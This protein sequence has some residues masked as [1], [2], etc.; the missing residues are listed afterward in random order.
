MIQILTNQH[1]IKTAERAANASFELDAEGK[2]SLSNPANWAIASSITKLDLSYCDDPA[3]C[4]EISAFANLVNLNCAGNELTTLD[5]SN[6]IA[7]ET[8][9]C[10][11]NNLEGLN[12][13]GNP[14]LKALN[15]CH[16]KLK[17]LDLSQN[18]HLIFLVCSYNKLAS[19]N[20]SELSELSY[21]VCYHNCL[22][23][24]DITMNDAIEMFCMRAGNQYNAFGLERPLKLMVN[25]IQA[26]E[27]IADEDNF[28]VESSLA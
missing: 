2:V 18:Q 27:R 8:L 26:S 5:V 21:L 25:V 3:I 19:L 16:N 7:L 24:L 28:G 6:N 11:E 12:I 4:D 15:C 23:S 14:G 9:D 10:S 13:S 1:L 20:V 17:E 22:G